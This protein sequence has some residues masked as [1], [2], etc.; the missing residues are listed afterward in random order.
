[1]DTRNFAK[2]AITALARSCVF[3]ILS[4]LGPFPAVSQEAAL[5]VVGETSV[6]EPI[7]VDW[8]GPDMPGDFLTLGKPDG[9]TTEFIS[10]HRTSL[11]S[12]AALTVSDAGVYEVRYVSAVGLTILARASVSVGVAENA[13]SAA[14]TDEIGQ[15]E[16][17]VN[18]EDP[19]QPVGAQAGTLFALVAVDAGS[20]F[21]VAWDITVGSRA[22][23]DLIDLATQTAVASQPFD[24]AVQVSLTA[25]TH[26][27]MFELRLIGSDG[28]S[29]AR[30]EV[31]VR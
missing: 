3:A 26:V 8:T 16:I 4:L 1:M 12:P 25:P 11:G 27:G 13:A 10:Y 5:S 23:V 2:I 29:L 22:R 21:R 7:T 24:G 6:G 15:A 19:A 18:L 28:R 9:E 20:S 14:T 17:N 30:R 31:E